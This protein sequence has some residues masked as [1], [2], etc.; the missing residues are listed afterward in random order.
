MFVEELA[1]HSAHP[2]HQLLLLFCTGGGKRYRDLVKT[3]KASEIERGLD[4]ILEINRAEHIIDTAR[5]VNEGIGSWSEK[6]CRELAVQATK[7]FEQP[8]VEAL[9]KIQILIR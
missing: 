5:G 4:I 1:R 7:S 6:G 9:I 3:Y 8:A 2:L